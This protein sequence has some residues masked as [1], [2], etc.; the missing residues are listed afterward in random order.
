MYCFNVKVSSLSFGGESAGTEP[1]FF[2]S[3][4]EV[5]TVAALIERTVTE[6]IKQQAKPKTMAKL[7]EEIHRAQQAFQENHYFI[8]ADGRQL[9][10]LDETITLRANSEVQ[11]IR[12]LPLIG[13]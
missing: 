5:L 4:V 7:P 13:G 1:I 11:F 12:L 9:T 6:Q 2:S 10:T 8:I 3:S